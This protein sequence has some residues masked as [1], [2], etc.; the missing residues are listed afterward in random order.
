MGSENSDP[1]AAILE[2][3][4]KVN[5]EV[6]S[7][8]ER[9]VTT[10]DLGT[11]SP[12]NVI[13]DSWRRCRDLGIDP[14]AVRAPS[15]LESEAIER[16]LRTASLGVVGCEVLRSY[17]TI[18]QGTGHVLVLADAKGRILHAAGQRGTRERLER[19]NFMPG[20]MWAEEVVGPNGVGTPLKLGRP[21]VVLGT[22]HFCLGWQPWVCYGSPV[23]DPESGEIIGVIDITG[24]VRHAQ[25]ETMGLTVAIAQA[26]EQQ[27]QL[28]ELVR[29]DHL[30]NRF[31]EV[32][33]RWPGDGLILLSR[34]GRVLDAN[35]AGLAA[36]SDGDGAVRNRRLIEVAP[37]LALGLQ[38]MRLHEHV[39]EGAVE[40]EIDGLVP[41]TLRLEVM[42]DDGGR[43]A[44]YLL[45]LRR[46]EMPPPVFAERPRY[47]RPAEDAEFERQPGGLAPGSLRETEEELIRRTL[48]QCGGEISR[49][50]R[51][52]GIARS[53]LYRRLK[54]AQSPRETR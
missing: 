24:P 17:E 33:R 29:R 9:F 5:R 10:G 50:A 48:A 51:R 40:R 21:E 42:R 16:I 1:F 23:R 47:A 34:S 45:V 11:R 30:H 38:G 52:L 4:V 28:R 19:I 15:R 26:V 20:G 22:E 36:V 46:K 6:A 31:L 7:A 35:A 32:Q 12:R 18:L 37:R 8:W 53:T 14:E 54:R 2:A 25:F 13:A 3:P 27:L 44:G 49:A 43:L 41:L 39:P